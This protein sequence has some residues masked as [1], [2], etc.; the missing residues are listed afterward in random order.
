MK[1][2]SLLFLLFLLPLLNLRAQSGEEY[3]NTLQAGYHFYKEYKIDYVYGDPPDFVYHYFR[4]SFT[5]ET[6]LLLEANS[7]NSYGLYDSNF[8]LYYLSTGGGIELPIEPQSCSSYGGETSFQT[9]LWPGSYTIYTTVR[10]RKRANNYANEYGIF[11]LE[12]SLKT[13]HPDLE[14]D[15]TPAPDSLQ[16]YI[17]H[18]ILLA[19]DSNES[20]TQD[21][22]YDG[23]G[24]EIENVQPGMTAA[25]NDLIGWYKEYDMNGRLKKQWLPFATSGK[26]GQFVPS[27][28]SK[29]AEFYADS[30]PFAETSYDI[31]DRPVSNA[32]EGE[33]WQG[34][35]VRTEYLTND[36]TG[37][38]RCLRYQAD[39]A[40]HLI[41]NGVYDAGELH[42][43]KSTDE[44]GHTTYTF[45]DKENRTILIRE[46]QG[47]TPC[48]T[49]HVYDS[50]RGNL[51]YILPPMYQD[52][53]DLGL[54]AYQYRYDGLNRC[55]T[56]KLPGADSIRYVYDKTDRLIYTQDGNQAKRKE[57]TFNVPD[58]FGRNV[59]TGIGTSATT[60]SPILQMLI[61]SARR[62]QDAGD[63]NSGY[64]VHNLREMSSIRPKEVNYYDDYSFLSLE[65][66]RVQNSLEY[67]FMEFPSSMGSEIEEFSTRYASATG[68]QTGQRIYQTNSD[69]YRVTASYYDRKGNLIQQRSTNLLGGTD[70]DFYAYT[71]T[72]LVKK[73]VHVHAVPDKS[74]LTESYKYIYDHAERLTK[75]IH[76]LNNGKEVVL[77]EKEYDELSRPAH[78]KLN[79]G[80]NKVDYSYNLRTWL[81]GISTPHFAQTLHYTDGEGVP[82]Y[83]GN[84]SSMT[85]QT[86]DQRVRGY[87]FAYDG[88]NRLTEAVYGEGNKLTSATNR[89]NEQ[90]TA[91]DKQGNILGMK[92][93]G[94]T[95]ASAYGLIDN[96]SLTY[97][98]NRLKS[99][100]DNAVSAAYQDGFEF[101][102][103]AN[104]ATEYYYDANGNLTKDLNKKITDIQYN[105]LNLPSQ[106]KF[107]DGS[108]FSY[109]Y[110][111]NG[112]KLRTTHLSGGKTLTTHYCGN[113]I[114]ENGILTRI[115]TEAGYITL[116]DGVYHYFISDHQG[117]NRVVI[118]QDGTAEEVNHY[119][120]F[121][122]LFAHSSTVQPYKY[123][124]KELD[125]TKGLNWYDYG[126]RMYDPALGRW[127]TGDPLMEKYYGGSPYMYC[128]NNPIRIID[129]DGQDG[130]DIIAGYGIGFITDIIP[131][132]SFLRDYYAP[133]DPSDYNDALQGID[134]ASVLFGEQMIKT[135][136]EGMAVGTAVATVGVVASAG[137]GGTL[138]VAG[139]PVAGIGG[140]LIEAGATATVAGAVM[141]ANGKQNQDAGY[142]RG[143]KKNEITFTQGQGEK[144]RKITT[145][146]PN[147][148]EKI[149]ER[150][151]SDMPIFRK[152]NV[153]ISPDK[154][155]HNGGIWKKAKSPGDFKN[156]T[157]RNGTYDKDLKRIGD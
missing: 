21:T 46:M 93:F 11:A 119:Y 128:R 43:T 112:T 45:T 154:D 19:P 135:G 33:A 91:Y 13:P 121:G 129:P 96:L 125:S 90:V 114:Y 150:S 100:K 23:L 40:G 25:G 107:E 111:A 20:M 85:W 52:Q 118:S 63:M 1:K 127:H 137:S 64:L 89:F 115:L 39:A 32:G 143:K 50:D 105:Y 71:F 151:K 97:N 120:P 139:L 110:D 73:H 8:Q 134:N 62:T 65:N 66:V 31:L 16:N 79:N 6:A 51:R 86:D 22:Y 84:I 106:I 81:T 103:N 102:D 95:S 47:Q 60:S 82:L 18:Q 48:D 61:V 54:Y 92:R 26:D 126:A 131:G 27:A 145:E 142:D 108:V 99:V 80:K 5:I 49:Y 38:L 76:R 77:S 14:P 44:D 69:E 75:V 74:T 153:Y 157:T 56:K 30:R 57:W 133:T 144:G 124:G 41:A 94:Q 136:G 3:L 123:N 70:A 117:N 140:T 55:I 35:T 53:P 148:F 78:V 10:D 12:F 42:V 29:V 68:L 2:I 109:L 147:G 122:G 116:P 24:R 88:V 138:A 149:K 4:A 72:G 104:S 67:G 28:P 9:V 146:I 141:M 130:W 17:R 7:C 152:G 132:T 58:R 15:P 98:G 87:K 34:K 36:A 37:N 59:L 156:R 83:N 101:K 113:A 155:G